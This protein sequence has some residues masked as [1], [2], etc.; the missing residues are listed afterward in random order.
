MVVLAV[1]ASVAALHDVACRSARPIEAI[2]EAAH[3]MLDKTGTV[4]DG[5]LPSSQRDTFRS[6]LPDMTPPSRPSLTHQMP[7]SLRGSLRTEL[8]RHRVNAFEGS[9][10]TPVISC[11]WVASSTR[12]LN[13]VPGS[14]VVPILLSSNGGFGESYKIIFKL[15]LACKMVFGPTKDLWF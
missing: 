11:L 5:F 4:A 15:P 14:E 1:I 3:V 8:E 10:S 7:G 2:C 9:A 13:F 12:W 6:Q